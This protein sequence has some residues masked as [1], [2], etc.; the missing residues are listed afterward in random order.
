MQEFWAVKDLLSWTTMYFRDKGIMEPRLEAEVLLARALK[1]DRVYLYSNY[2]APVNKDERD[3]FKTFIRRRIQGEPVAYITGNREFMSLDFEVSPAVLIPR[4]DTE[5][6][7]ETALEL[8]KK[9]NLKRICDVGTGSGAIAISIAA[10]IPDIIMYA[11]EIS[12]EAIAVAHNNAVKHSVNINL[13]PGDLLDPLQDE[14]K[15]DMILANLPYIP[16]AEYIEL[17]FQVRAYEPREALLAPGDGLDLYRRLIPQAYKLLKPGGYI[18]FEIG[19]NQGAAALHIMQDFTNVE[20]ITDMGRR[21]RV[22]KARKGDRS[23]Y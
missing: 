10:S 20:L 9:Y 8:I 14:E 21:N 3:L 18:L 6:L 12:A 19:Y 7:V 15:L 4:P 17:E 16:E 5:I 22:V 2:M 1:Q 13:C 23:E 11:T